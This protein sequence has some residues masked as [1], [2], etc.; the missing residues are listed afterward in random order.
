[1]IGRNGRGR[2]GGAWLRSVS[3]GQLAEEVVAVEAGLVAIA[4]I[5]ADGVVADLFPTADGHA[6]EFFR[7]VAA[8]L[9][10]QNVTLADV[11]GTGR[12]GAQVLHREIRLRTVFPDDG[13]FVADELDV[14]G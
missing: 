2:V 12:R 5:E 11:G 14:G 8:I 10:S 9:V 7:A 4:E 1:M 13:D 6:R 3:F